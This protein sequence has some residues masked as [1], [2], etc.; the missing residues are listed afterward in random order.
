[1]AKH[2][3]TTRTTGKLQ[4]TETSRGPRA[5][6]VRRF[7]QLQR[8]IQLLA[9]G[10][11]GIS[12]EVSTLKARAAPASF[13]ERE[14]L[15]G[16]RLSPFFPLAKVHSDE[17]GFIH[18]LVE[19][20]VGSVAV[21]FSKAGTTRATH[22]H[23]EDAHLCY[24]VSGL[25]EYFERPVGSAAAPV[26]NLIEAGRS[27]FTGPLVEHTMYFPQDTV[28]VTIGGHSR[29]QEDYEK[30]LVRLPKSLREV[31]EIHQHLAAGAPT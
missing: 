25:I 20:P 19:E 24:V 2:K 7:E 29:T 1:M 28:F 16:A 21:I 22:F 13:F 15:K 10:M 9:E 8:D 14:D 17:R 3:R 30:D 18:N 4:A 26:H 27:F 5:V 31:W 6:E 11:L 12:E 23:R